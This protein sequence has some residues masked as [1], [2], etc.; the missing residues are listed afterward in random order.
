M[1]MPVRR[2]S[3]PLVPAG[4]VV[5]MGLGPGGFRGDGE[6]VTVTYAGAHL[7]TGVPPPG[8]C[9]PDAESADLK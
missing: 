4:A 8:A 6:H 2:T 1:L 5:V 7:C 9:V 3:V